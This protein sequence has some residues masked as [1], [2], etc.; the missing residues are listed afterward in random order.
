MIY[1][2]ATLTILLSSTNPTGNSL[3]S[4]MNASKDMVTLNLCG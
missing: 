2:P 3:Y 4:A 1:L